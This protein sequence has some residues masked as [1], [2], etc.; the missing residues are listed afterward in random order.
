MGSFSLIWFFTFVAS[1][2]ALFA[3]H[4][5]FK[6]S[7][8][9][10]PNTRVLHMTGFDVSPKPVHI[11][12]NLSVT[13]VGDLAHRLQTNS[14]YRLNVTMDKKLLSNWHAVPCAHKVGTCVYDDPCEF[15]QTFSSNHTCPQAF[16]DNGLS[17]TCPFDPVTLNVKNAAVEVKTI[18]QAW[19]FLANGDFRARVEVLDGSKMI[20]CLRAELSITIPCHGFLCGR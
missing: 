15:L 11:P 19:S 10:D 12:G 5:T 8:C 16:I 18:P 7:D 2:F 6:W 3:T 20:G 17:C 13:I 1:G 14:H 9:S 4:N